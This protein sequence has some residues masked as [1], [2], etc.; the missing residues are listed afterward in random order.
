MMVFSW[1]MA[2]MVGV[3]VLILILVTCFYLRNVITTCGPGIKRTDSTLTRNPSFIEKSST[4]VSSS[5]GGGSEA[6]I[7]FT[8]QMSAVSTDTEIRTEN[9]RLKR[10]LSD[11]AESNSEMEAR[12]SDIERRL[13]TDLSNESEADK[14]TMSKVF[15]NTFWNGNS[16]R[17]ATSS[18]TLR[19]SMSEPGEK[20]RSSVGN[21]AMN[22]SGAPSK[23]P[24]DFKAEL[25]VHLRQIRRLE[26]DT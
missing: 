3:I 10:R 21:S 11:L 19:S 2:L 24:R 12:L 5:V 8:P 1:W 9:E 25:P 17:G 26:S 14:T 15:D 6:S 18:T 7:D 4:S 23:P 13:S 16:V 20:V 22:P